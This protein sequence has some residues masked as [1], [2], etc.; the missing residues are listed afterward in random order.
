MYQ[1]SQFPP[2]PVQTQKKQYKSP[3]QLWK[4]T[5]KKGK[6]GI[7]AA[8]ALLLCS[9]CICGSVVATAVSTPPP[10]L[11]PTS[12]VTIMPTVKATSQ[13]REVATVAPTPIPTAI[14]PT[15][16]PTEAPT[17]IPTSPPVQTGVNG[18]PWGYDFTAGNY[19]YSP[20]PSFCDYF[21]CVSTFWKDT[22]GYVAECYNGSYTHSGGISGAC[23]RDGGVEQPL[24]SH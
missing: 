11:S 8:S 14:P 5:G 6:C 7:I 24:Y 17:P 1:P 4:D 18:N 22:N 21:T 23:S 10:P 9:L 12:I 19:I 2:P 20:D 15:P 3:K 13:L 16:V